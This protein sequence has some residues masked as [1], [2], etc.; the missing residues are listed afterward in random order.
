[1]DGHAP[2][3]GIARLAEFADERPGP[4]Y[5]VYAARK[6]LSPRI[7]VLLAPLERVLATRAWNRPTHLNPAP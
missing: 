6:H 5:A 3:G 1:M 2:F 7:R 4:L